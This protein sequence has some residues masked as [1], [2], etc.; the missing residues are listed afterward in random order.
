MRRAQ[1][2]EHRDER[3]R[4]VEARVEREHLVA[5]DRLARHEVDVG[6]DAPAQRDD[7]RREDDR[8]GDAGVPRFLHD[9]RAVAVPASPYARTSP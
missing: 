8:R 5:R 9:L 3:A 6:E 2:A 1:V 7:V 4:G